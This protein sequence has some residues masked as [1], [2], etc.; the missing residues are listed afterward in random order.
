MKKFI[1]EILLIQIIATYLVI[2]G[3]SYPFTSSTPVWLTG[4]R[5]FLYTFHMPLFVWVSGYLIV[6]TKQVTNCTLPAFLRKRCRKL[7]IPYIILSLLALVPKFIA[8]PYLNDD[9]KLDTMT[10]VRTIFVPRE[11]VWGHFWF[12]P[13]IFILG[14]AGFAADRSFVKANNQKKGWFMLTCV[15]FI[16]YFSTYRLDICRWFA[17]NDILAFGWVF[18]LGALCGCNEWLRHCRSKYGIT[19]SIS[20]FAF[21]TTI[22]C[23]PI[24]A[25]LGQAIQNALVAVCMIYSLTSLCVWLSHRVNIEKDALYAQTFTIFLLSWPCQ[26]MT[27]VIAE[28]F[29]ELPCYAVMPLQFAAGIAGPLVLIHLIGLIENKLK[30]N[31]ISYSLGK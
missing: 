15:F 16:L 27:N 23:I 25:I 7:I 9:M 20:S 12:L 26:A 17:I 14:V 22:F 6:C 30:I 21:A 11:N 19:A 10:L 31:W 29:L 4:A 5:S 24:H 8:Q 1:S 13:M 2:L 28:R 18:C 3:H